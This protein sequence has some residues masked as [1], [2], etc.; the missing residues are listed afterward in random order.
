MTQTVHHFPRLSNLRATVALGLCA[1][2]LSA[3]SLAATVEFKLAPNL[4]GREY[5]NVLVGIAELGKVSS[6]SRDGG[7]KLE[8]ASDA[9]AFSAMRALRE[10]RSVLWASAP[11]LEMPARSISPVATDFHERMISIQ[12]LE[13]RDANAVVSRLSAATGRT[14]RLKRVATGNRAMVILPSDTTASSMAAVT[15]AATKDVDVASASRVRLMRHHWVSNDTLLEQQWSLGNGVGGIRAAAA[16][17]IT[18]SGSVQVAIIDTGIR[19]HPDL[20]AKRVIGYDMIREKFISLDG[21]G[22]DSDP[23]D[24]GD[25]DL[26]GICADDPYAP[27]TWHGT[28]VAG[29]VGASTNNKEGIAGVAPN[30]RIQSVRVLGRCFGGTSEDVADAI[31]WAAGV[32]VP[33]VP[34]NPMPSK[35]INLS[36]G[37]EGPCEANEQSAIDAA[38]ANGAIIVVS[39]G[40]EKVDASE[41]SPANCRGVITVAASNI[42]G[43]LASYS[44]FGE[45]VTLSA[46]GGDGGLARLPAILSTLNGNGSLPAE[47]SYAT[48]YGTSMAAPHV[49]GVV[50]MMVARDPSLTAGQALNRLKSSARSFPP[51]TACAGAPGQCGAGLLDAANAVASV[52]LNRG[53]NEVSSSN[54]RLQLVEL[55][56][57]NSGR[58]ILS[59]DP[60]EIARL[61]S[62]GVWQRTG[63]VISTFSFTTLYGLGSSVAQPVC[64]ATLN[65][66]KAFVYS[67][68]VQECKNYEQSGSGFTPHGVVFA[69]A[70]PNSNNCPTGSDPVWDLAK[71]DSLGYNV[72]T[73]AN[74]TEISQMLTQGWSYSRVAFCAPN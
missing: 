33:G 53:V 17:D 60:A 30:A 46:P 29:I 25:A 50:A 73:I 10:R 24:P 27:S 70:L 59:A 66:G 28:H 49:A 74:T 55:V 48:Y 7:Y 64:R 39:A 20:D 22:R 32:P 9:A 51:G 26:D 5:K 54:D 61:V 36:L 47:P 38:I 71:L 11:S 44:N 72:R 19:A 31:R 65:S 2:T 21:S 67:T 13:N 56:N 41:V 18:P 40:N 14:M 68:N 57:L 6:I 69:A 37:G 15:V 42:L 45:A 3:A 1:M 63:Q 23:S 16:W 43:E 8:T 12:L 62:T 35:V 34:L 58:Y 52:G 4:K